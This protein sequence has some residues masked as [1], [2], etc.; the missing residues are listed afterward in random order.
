MASTGGDDSDPYLRECRGV[1]AGP[2]RFGAHA[3][4]SRLVVRDTKRVIVVRC[5]RHVT[6]STADARFSRFTRSQTPGS[7]RL[8]TESAAAGVAIA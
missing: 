2:Y 6:L 8:H 5:R 1:A 7:D 3:F 4:K